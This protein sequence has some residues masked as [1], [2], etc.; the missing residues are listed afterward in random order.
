MNEDSDQR[1]GKARRVDAAGQD[2]TQSPL[3]SG[4]LTLDEPTLSVEQAR[5]TSA[6]GATKRSQRPLA[7]AVAAIEPDDALWNSKSFESQ[8]EIGFGVIARVGKDAV[9]RSPLMSL[10]DE[11]AEVRAIRGG[12]EAHASRQEERRLKF[13][14]EGDLD[15]AGALEFSRRPAIPVVVADVTGVEAG[16]VDGGDGLVGDQAT[17]AGALEDGIEEVVE[18]PFFSKRCSATQRVE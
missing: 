18:D 8:L 7:S 15:P 3:V 12:A 11:G 17:L 1:L 10:G 16:G 13:G 5:E 14:H 6:E 9:E 2:R 4:D